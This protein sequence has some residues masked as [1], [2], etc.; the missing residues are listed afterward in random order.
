MPSGIPTFDTVP[1][2][3]RGAVSRVDDLVERA[4]PL[5]H[6]CLVL[7]RHQAWRSIRHPDLKAV[8]PFFGVLDKEEMQGTL[9]VP[10]VILI[11]SWPN[12]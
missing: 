9:Q 7:R 3:L 2:D 6:F 5:K 11:K 4:D 1:G 10:S 8:L 12:T